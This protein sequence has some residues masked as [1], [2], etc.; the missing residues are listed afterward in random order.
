[1]NG[2]SF[3]NLTR[4]TFVLYFSTKKGMRGN[5]KEKIF[6]VNDVFFRN[7]KKYIILRHSL[8]KVTINSILMFFVISLNKNY[9]II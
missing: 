1:M 6:F 5:E 8:V 3:S 2:C 4:N 9:E 7:V